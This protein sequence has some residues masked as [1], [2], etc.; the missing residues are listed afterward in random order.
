MRGNV[1]QRCIVVFTAMVYAGIFLATGVQAQHVTRIKGEQLVVNGESFFA[2]SNITAELTRLAQ[3]DGI[4]APNDN[5]KQIAVSGASNSSVVQ[6]Y[7]NCNPK[8]IYLISDAGVDLM[9]D[10]HCTDE[11][12]IVIQKCKQ[13]LLSYLEE[14][15]KNGT[16][17]LLWQIYPDPQNFP[18]LKTNQDIWAQ[19]VP[20]VMANVTEPKVIL[21]DLRK[22]WAGHYNQYTSDGIHC[23][24]EGGRAT[25]EAFWK[26]MKENNFFDTAEV[27]S[28]KHPLQIAETTPVK[29]IGHHVSNSTL[30]LSLSLA[31]PTSGITMRV[32]TVSGRTIITASKQEQLSGHQTVKFPL[33]AI[34]SGVY[35]VEIKTGKFFERSLIVVN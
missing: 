20:K 15:R 29:I 32:T 18:V 33:G 12:C 25:A 14:M 11:N 19:V 24:S 30:S 31:Q 26:A 28:T 9:T 13:I 6:F 17:K 34:A 21:V 23:T 2:A 4:L 8:P 1:M 22:V 5:F 16:K 27:V 35:R 10:G 3:A 7:K